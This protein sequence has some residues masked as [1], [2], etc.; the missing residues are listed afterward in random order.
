VRLHALETDPVGDR[1]YRVTAA[2]LIAAEPGRRCDRERELDLAMM[3]WS[4]RFAFAT[5]STLAWRWG[6]S[7][8]KMRKRVRRLEREGLMRRMQD[9]RN[10]PARVVVTERGGDA[11]GL[12][13]R[14]ARGLESL[15]HE[16]A[17]IKRVMAIEA[18]FADHGPAGARVLTEREMRRE[19]RRDD[20]PMWSVRVLLPHGRRAKRWPDYVVQSPAGTTAVELEFSLKATRRLRSILLGYEETPLYD[21]VDFV[22]PERQQD[23]QLAR[24]LWRLVDEVTTRR[25]AW[26]AKWGIKP[27][28]EVRVVPWRDPLPELHSGIAPFPAVGRPS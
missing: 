26:T 2:E 27:G 5:C 24:T 9:G 16:I 21:F 6:V 25:N 3:A 4:A 20:G 8:Q 18:Y 1:A 14:T 28:P 12:T 13:I 15:G 22:V 10:Q 7:E 19:Q 23:A 17:V 11:C